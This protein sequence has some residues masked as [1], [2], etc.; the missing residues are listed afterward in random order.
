MWV[1]AVVWLGSPLFAAFLATRLELAPAPVMA[2]VTGVCLA[3][4]AAASIIT[5]MNNPRDIVTT[6]LNTYTS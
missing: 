1:E 6:S 2:F 3:A 4:S 5:T